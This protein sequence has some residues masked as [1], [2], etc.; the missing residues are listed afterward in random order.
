MELASRTVK[1]VFL[2]LGGN[3]PAIVLGDAALDNDAIARMTRAILR[4]SGQ[5]CIAIK[6]AYVH[7]SIYDA[8]CEELALL[9]DAAVMGDVRADQE[10]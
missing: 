6:R 10:N 4:A 5:V 2:E 9:A 3:D 1:K 8:M 7:D